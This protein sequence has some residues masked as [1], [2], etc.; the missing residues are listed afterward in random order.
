[1]STDEETDF[2][3]F[4]Y[5]RL[6][7]V[8][9]R[10]ALGDAHANARIHA[11]LAR[12]L[13]DAGASLV[14]F[15]ELSLTGYSCEDLFMQRE[16]Q[17]SVEAAIARLASDTAELSCAL[18]AGAPWLLADGRLVNC[19]FVIARGE[20]RGGVPK[21]AIPSSAEFYEQR[22]FAS[23]ED[24]DAR[25]THPVLGRFSIAPRQIFSLGPTAFAIE[26]CED[27]WIADAPGN[28][29]ALAGAEIILN[30]SA[31]PELVAKCSY[32]RDLVRMA[33][34]SRICG[35]LYASSGPTESS[36]DLVFGGHLIAAENGLMLGESERFMLEGTHLMVDFDWQALRHDRA[37][38][39]TFA[40]ARRPHGYAHIDTD[41]HAQ[42][43]ADIHRSY[44]RTPFV[45]DGDDL[46][47]RAEEILSIQATGLAR[48]I[49][50]ANSKRL[51]LGVS[52]GL[53]ST[54]A[55]LVCL[56][57]LDMIERPHTDLVLISMPGP[58]TS[59]HTQDSV[60]L[61]AGA[62][63]LDLIEIPI[64]A[65]VSAHL[66]NLGHEQDEDLVFENAQARERTQILFDYAGKVDGL[67]VGTGDL[68]EL[69][70]GWCTFNAD[71]MASYAVNAS[72]PKTLVKHLIQ[73]H[74]ERHADA[75][76]EGVLQRV[77]ST[78]ISP[79]LTSPKEDGSVGQLTEEIIG[80]YELHDFFL[81][82]LMRSG[83]SEQKIRILAE[84]SFAGAYAPEEIARWLAL[85]RQRFFS[86]QYKR[87]TLPPGPKVGSVSLSPRGDWRMPDEVRP[88]ATET[89][90]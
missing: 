16:L 48:R 77:I 44:A 3:D 79:E 37:R 15:P 28:R 18:V 49:M 55:L 33:S 40:G 8:S 73:Y 41:I 29:H 85:F 87:T 5:V 42:P 34:A 82:Q 52:G 72:V 89:S 65:A 36:K 10:L 54:L 84:R 78:P 17:E 14:L 74:A 57:A 32:R 56:R 13:A 59:A 64:H 88:R 62:L 63:A 22:W 25:I 39:A 2:S 75:A 35:L 6:A 31:S 38:N 27:L 71:H 47:E 30:L 12:T 61:I 66:E 24:V 80:P 45:P 1:M 58:G 69:A 20:V 43:L 50:A 23:G 60:A 83:F 67:V 81:F 90:T 51:V 21:Q 11:R 70:L 19:A 9:P 7:A 26:V 86:Q 46:G 68:S 4:G 53:D 76:L